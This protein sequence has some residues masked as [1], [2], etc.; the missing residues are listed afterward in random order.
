MALSGTRSNVTHFASNGERAHPHEV[1]RAGVL[2]AVVVWFW[3]LIIGALNGDPLRVAT[4]IGS[5]LTHV[6]GVRATPG[7]VAVLVFTVFHFVVWLGIAKVIAV[8]LRV[9]VG[10][11][12]VLMLATVVSILVL[13][14]LVGI[15]MIFAS[16][17]LGDV[18]AWSAM[19]AGSIIGLTTA[20]W[21]ILHHHP[22]VRGE[23]A[24]VDDD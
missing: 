8:V 18:F 23:L 1:L 4:M 19:Y 6:V 16:E 11:P 13:L 17:G 5:G 10:T 24:H 15:T 3:I 14:A 21:Y 20:A 7:W 22:E 2:G 9:A 12:A